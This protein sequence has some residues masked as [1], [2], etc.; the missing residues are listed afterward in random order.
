MGFHDKFFKK[1]NNKIYY[2]ENYASSKVCS[3]LLDLIPFTT[4]KELVIVCIGTDRCTG[5]SLGPIIGTKL[6]EQRVSNFNIYGTLEDPVHALNLQET[7]D[8]INNSYDSP[9][10][11]GIDACL[12]KKE[13]IG[14]VQ[15]N[16]GPVIPGAAV[17]KKLPPVGN[18]HISGIVNIG[19]FM[20]F[21]VLQNTRL[22]IVMN[23]ANVISDSLIK[24]DRQ[25]SI[26]RHSEIE[27]DSSM[28]A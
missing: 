16:D 3:Y 20:E 2:N 12:G 4:H 1:E 24:A 23:L 6:Q 7:L 14:A 27:P 18:M 8:L 19:G 26:Y 22:S 15:I 10:V 25:I 13:N 5:D 17:N 11:I 28:E 21:S 9:Y